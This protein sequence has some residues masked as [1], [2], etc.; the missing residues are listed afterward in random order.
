MPDDNI[1]QEQ[2]LEACFY[3]RVE[4]VGR[5]LGAGGDIDRESNEYAPLHAAAAG[6]AVAVVT[7]LLERGAQVD[8]R[9]WLGYTPLFMAAQRGYLP[10]VEALL[11]GG[12]DVNAMM[13]G[14]MTALFIA[15]FCEQT[16]VVAR[17]LAAGAVVAGAHWQK[18]DGDRRCLEL[19]DACRAGTR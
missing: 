18:G 7:L 1:I 10:C 12:A 19:V 15:A 4:E 11:A 5:L 8:I 14:T 2:L 3:G 6:G 13:D 17:L 16:E 9:N